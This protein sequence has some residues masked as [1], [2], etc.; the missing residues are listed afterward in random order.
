MTSFQRPTILQRSVVRRHSIGYLD[1]QPLEIVRADTALIV[2]DTLVICNVAGSTQTWT[3]WHVP[4]GEDVDDS[5]A[6]FHQQTIASKRSTVVE[7]PV[8]LA[9]GERL[10]A[11]ASAATSLVLT[12]YERV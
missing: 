11:E 4:S 7:I 3:V 10:Y 9:P 2:I 12:A 6:L 1:T 5:H 8:P